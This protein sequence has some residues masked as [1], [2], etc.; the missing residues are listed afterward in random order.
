MTHSVC[1][2]M[3]LLQAPQII[4]HNTGSDGS[5]REAAMSLGKP[6]I[7]VEIG[8]PSSFQKTYIM[9]ALQGVENVLSYLGMLHESVETPEMFPTI[10]VK[11]HWYYAE[12]GCTLQ[13]KPTVNQWVK[14][15]EVIAIVRNIFGDLVHRYVAEEDGVVIGRNVDPVCQSGDRLI[16]L[17][18]V[19]R[20]F[21]QRPTST[22]PH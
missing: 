20:D 19:G 12:H 10:C 8:N 16:L 3:A 14:K 5:L 22:K 6:A 9:H 18:T 17:G 2:Q 15:G 7:T 21:A 11:S 13:V 1:K 4:V